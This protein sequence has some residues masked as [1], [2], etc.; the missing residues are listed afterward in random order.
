MF[1]AQTPSADTQ[2]APEV[3]EDSS[4]QVEVPVDQ[5][6]SCFTRPCPPPWIQ[7]RQPLP[8]AVSSSSP[9]P[10]SPG[11]WNVLCPL[12]SAAVYPTS[13][14]FLPAPLPGGFFCCWDP[15][16]RLSQFVT[17]ELALL[18]LD[19]AGDGLLCSR[20]QFLMGKGPLITTGG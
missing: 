4:V 9:P 1:R 6:G 17:S 19:E 10:G 3:K 12:Q 15:S 20:A 2:E 7:L 14:V 16:E 5:V 8:T 13:R 18:L 11:L